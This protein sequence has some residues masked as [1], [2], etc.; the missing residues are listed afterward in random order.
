[1]G[2]CTNKDSLSDVV[3]FNVTKNESRKVADG[4]FFKFKSPDNQTALVGN[5]VIALVYNDKY[6]PCLIE[7]TLGQDAVKVLQNI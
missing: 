4:N 6:K 5:K 3:V 1:M 2:G 7:W